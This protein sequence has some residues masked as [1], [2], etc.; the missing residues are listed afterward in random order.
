M[1]EGEEKSKQDKK[2]GSHN[3]T[4]VRELEGNKFE[5]TTRYDGRLV[6]WQAIKKNGVEA[7]DAP[8]AKALGSK[9]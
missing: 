4:C 9:Y 8:R 1:R 2:I 3:E 7:A 5:C 6:H